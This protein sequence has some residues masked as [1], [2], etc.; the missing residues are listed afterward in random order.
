MNYYIHRNTCKK[1]LKIEAE[2]AVLYMF[3]QWIISGGSKIHVLVFNYNL[4]ILWSSSSLLQTKVITSTDIL[5]T[6]FNVHN[7]PSI[8]L[9]MLY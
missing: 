3:L 2:V 1:C 8:F 9:Y 6:N 5:C 7:N 4:R